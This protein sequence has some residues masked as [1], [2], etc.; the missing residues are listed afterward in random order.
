MPIRILPKD[1]QTQSESK[2]ITKK[3]KPKSWIT[4]KKKPTEWITKKKKWI[5]KKKKPTEWIT[6]K[7][8]W[9]TKKKK[10]TEW[11]K[12]KSPTDVRKRLIDSLSGG[13]KAKPHSSAEGRRASA[14]RRFSRI[15]EKQKP[16]T[17]QPQTPPQYNTKGPKGVGK[18]HA[19]YALGS[20]VK[21][22]V[23]GAKKVVGQLKK[24]K[25]I[26]YAGAGVGGWELG[27]KTSKKVNK[28]ASGGRIGLKDGGSPHTKDRQRPPK[29]EYIQSGKGGGWTPKSEGIKRPKY[30]SGGRIGLK[31]GGSAGAAIRGHGAE[32]K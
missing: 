13:E 14:G 9:I 25:G 26:V 16:K 15:V 7:K 2:W 29:K 32:I 23:K 1:E 22:A 31:H 10:P 5:T 11:I 17:A 4:K 27:K 21:G 28:K 8:N 18:L 3:E 6:K 20:L 19:G 30:K 24:D 12:R